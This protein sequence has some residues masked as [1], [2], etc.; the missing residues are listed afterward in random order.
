[1]KKVYGTKP[2]ANDKITNQKLTKE[3]ELLPFKVNTPT[4]QDSRARH[5][6]QSNVFY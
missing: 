5:F 2:K 1:M 4:V 3:R 6:Y